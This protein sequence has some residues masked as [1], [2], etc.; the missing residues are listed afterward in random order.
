MLPFSL[1]N[2]IKYL[3]GVLLV[4]G[5]TVLLVVTAYRTDLEQTGL[6]FLLLNLAIGTLTAFW[7]TSMAEGGRKQALSR[8]KEGFAREREKLRVHA[9]REKAKEVKNNQRRISRERQR[10]QQGGNLKTS[11]MLGGAAGLGVVMVLAQFVTLGLLTLTTAGGA[12]LGYG[13][14]ARQDRLGFGIGK[15]LPRTEKPVQVIE[16]PATKQAITN[17]KRTPKAASV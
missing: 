4:Q 12:A 7:F 9:E 1:T 5:V 13:L 10:A 6:L 15:L 11:L 8:A 14:R 2:F 3:I 17:K 16:T